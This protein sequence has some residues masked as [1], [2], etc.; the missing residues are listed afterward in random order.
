MIRNFSLLLLTASLLGCAEIMPTVD[1]D[2]LDVTDISFQDI[3]VDFV[4][5]VNNPNPIDIALDSLSYNLGFEAINVIS[6]A[7]SD[8]FNIRALT[9]SEFRMPVNLNFSDAWN[10]VEATRGEDMID[11]SLD[12]SFGF[13]TEY[14]PLDLPYQTGGEFPA[15]R[16]PSITLGALRVADVD[17]FGGTATVDID[18]NVD[19][20]H[21]SDLNLDAFAYD[22]TLDGNGVA[23]GILNSLG[24][25]AGA[26]SATM[27]LPVEIN[28]LS[29]GTSAYSAIVNGGSVDLGLNA[30]MDV[31][32]PFG[33][34]PLDLSTSKALNVT[35]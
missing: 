23:D 8:G 9:G 35:L 18:M 12:G 1:F 10:A 17:I 28:L 13:D 22:I 27:T 11:F 7:D 26:S 34:V 2:T 14:G 33:V 32:T 19:N 25:V 5:W 15:L 29:L 3:D 24:S 31:D 30:L 4:F 21:E 16:I 20:D 6:G